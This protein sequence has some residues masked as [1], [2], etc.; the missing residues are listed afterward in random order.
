[1]ERGTD[2]F[3]SILGVFNLTEEYNFDGGFLSYFDNVPA[4]RAPRD[5]HGR[6]RVRTRARPPCRAGLRP[7]QQINRK[8]SV[9]IGVLLSN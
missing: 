3:L 4:L 8:N 9:K 1:M 5:H 2:V 7:I 6:A